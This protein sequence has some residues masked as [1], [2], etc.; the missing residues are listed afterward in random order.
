M[1]RFCKNE[2]YGADRDDLMY[3]AASSAPRLVTCGT[4][5][6]AGSQQCELAAQW[7]GGVRLMP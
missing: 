2:S 3:L 7:D 4:N 5:V 6:R 1:V